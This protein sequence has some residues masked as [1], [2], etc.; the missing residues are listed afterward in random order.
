M[1]KKPLKLNNEKLNW[2][3]FKR[4]VELVSADLKNYKLFATNPE[5]FLTELALDLDPYLAKEAVDIYLKKRKL[6]DNPYLTQVRK[7][8][9][10]IYND[11]AQRVDIANFTAPQ[12]QK[13]IQR[14]KKAL[15]WESKEARKILSH[16]NAPVMF[17][18]SQGCSGQC[19]FCCLDTR[20]LTETYRYTEDNKKF[21]REILKVTKEEVGDAASVGACY[22]ATEPLDDPDYE[23]FIADFY[24]IFQTFPQ[25]TTVKG[26][27]NIKRIKRLMKQL[28]VEELQKAKLRFSIVSLEQLKAIYQNYTK[29]ELACVELLMNNK[30]SIY[31]YSDSGRARSFH[32]DGKNFATA[33]SVCLI[34]FL[35]NLCGKTISLTTPRKPSKA[36]PLGMEIISSENFSTSEDYREVIRKMIK[37]YMPLKIN[38]N[39]QLRFHSGISMKSKGN[40][41]TFL[42]EKIKQSLSLSAELQTALKKLQNE[43]YLVNNIFKEKKYSNFLCKSVLNKLQYLY[44][45]GFLEILER[46]E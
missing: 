30:E 41:V 10:P 15:A 27:A 46:K 3:D 24:Q 26:V 8:I 35:V 6:I 9:Q 43:V 16:F 5:K 7:L 19:D 29:E 42:G 1:V 28:G 18:L 2:L 34:G 21:W 39:H 23:K 17:E 4:L 13:W 45:L 25:T 36:Y 32:K 31:P 44:N 11:I 37:T 38:K 20:V 22:F 33:P 14:K 40:T 12:F